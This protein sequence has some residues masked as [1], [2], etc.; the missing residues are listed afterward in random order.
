MPSRTNRVSQ[1]KHKSDLLNV[2]TFT[3]PWFQVKRIYAEKSVHFVKLKLWQNTIIN[4]PG[5][6][7]AVLQTPL[8]FIKW[9]SQSAF[10]SKSSQHHESQSKRARKL[11]FWENVHHP[12][13]VTC[14]VSIFF[15]LQRGWASWWRVCYQQSLPCL[16]FFF[17][18]FSFLNI[19]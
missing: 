6:A 18:F 1:T 9:V 17:F 8:S 11:K 19:H 3:Q 15:F 4:R 14:Q 7:R 16:F 5:V 2:P 13:C 12:L 10:S